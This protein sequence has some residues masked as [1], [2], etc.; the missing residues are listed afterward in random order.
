M[1][2]NSPFGFESRDYRRAFWLP[3]MNNWVGRFIQ[4][5]N[6][7]TRKTELFHWRIPI[8]QGI[9][10]ILAEIS[11]RSSGDCLWISSSILAAPF[12]LIECFVTRAFVGGGHLHPL[13]RSPAKD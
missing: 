9:A 10:W 2:W 8:I 3:E 12:H 5:P 13:Q 4:H 6:E 1:S 7:E 11:S